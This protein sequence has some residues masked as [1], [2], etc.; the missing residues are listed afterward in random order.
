MEGILSGPKVIM[1]LRRVLMILVLSALVC[2]ATRSAAKPFDVEEFTTLEE[3]AAAV[4]E[5]VSGARIVAAGGSRDAS[6]TVKLAVVAVDIRRSDIVSGLAR[7][8]SASGRFNVIDVEK[9]N[10]FLKGRPPGSDV[11]SELERTF[12]LDAVVAVRGYPAGGKLLVIA[13]IISVQDAPHPGTIM[14]LL[15]LSPAKASVGRGEAMPDPPISA[16]YF[17]EADFDGDGKR[18]YL[19]SD[20]ERLHV[21]RMEASG[22]VRVWAEAPTRVGGEG[23][24]LHIDVAD[25]NANGKPEI[26]VTRML[27]GTVSSV[28]F[29][30]KDGTYRRIADLPGFVRVLSNPGRGPL[31]IGQEFQ[32]ERFFSG[33]PKQYSWSTGYVAGDAIPLPK[34]VGLYGFVFADVGEARPLVVALDSENRLRVYSQETLI[35]QSRERYGGID[36]VLVES[37]PDAYSSQQR[38][39]IPGRIFATDIDGDGIEEIIVARGGEKTIFGSVTKFEIHSLQWT[40]ARLEQYLAIREEP[41]AVLDLRLAPRNGE[42]IRIDALV[43]TAGGLLSSQGSRLMTYSYHGPQSPAPAGKI[44]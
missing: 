21:Y 26:F 14:G 24:H 33:T 34:G 39:S 11:I 6:K 31:L 17:A 5:R 41:G 25:I 7:R 3:F 30:E 18:E 9:T 40:G 36:T 13:R 38:V 1:L 16:R 8:L 12:G 44:E 15:G 10:A 22:W 20:G 29:E 23:R 43:R 42:G 35:W 28:V 19:F 4:A 37:T 32:E 2:P 27:K